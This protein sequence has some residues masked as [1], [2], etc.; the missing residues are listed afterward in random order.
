MLVT[1]TK[2]LFISLIVV[3][4]DQTSKYYILGVLNLDELGTSNFLP[5]VIYLK[6]AWNTGINFG[7]FANNLMIVRVGLIAIS[8]LISTTI[9]VYTVTHYHIS[10]IGLLSGVF[11]G[12]ALGNTI[13]RI[14]HGAVIDFLNVTCCGIVN[15]Y[16]FNIADTAIVVG[17]VG[18]V[19]VWSGKA[20]NV[21]Q[22]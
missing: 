3:I 15:P 20:R 4:L 16:S 18:M 12:G 22:D 10:Y 9:F 8:L 1:A 19:L 7:L 6:F 14:V 11:I 17:A 5:P 21:G 2:S 13:D